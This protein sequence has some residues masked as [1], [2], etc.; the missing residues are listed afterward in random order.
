MFQTRVGKCTDMARVDTAPGGT[1]SN[2]VIKNC[3]K[4]RMR[5]LGE[6]A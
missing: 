2:V 5:L 4:Y 6:D 1:V 3:Y